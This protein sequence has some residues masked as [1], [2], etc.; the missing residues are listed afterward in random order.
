MMIRGIPSGLV[1]CKSGGERQ[2]QHNL[3]RAILPAY[4]IRGDAEEMAELLLEEAF[5]K[6]EGA[7]QS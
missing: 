6:L 2:L 4:A 3:Q 7:V 1:V 5:N